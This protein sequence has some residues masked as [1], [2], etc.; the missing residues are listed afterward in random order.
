MGHVE[1]RGSEP[2]RSRKDDLVQRDEPGVFSTEHTLQSSSRYKSEGLISC[3]TLGLSFVGGILFG[4]GFRMSLGQH[5]V[6]L[7]SPGDR[8]M[9]ILEDP[10]RACP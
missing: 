8:T 4:Q 5:E 2:S 9:Y 7:L 10:G 6:D 1:V 3:K